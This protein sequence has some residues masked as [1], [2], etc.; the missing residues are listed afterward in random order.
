MPSQRI[1]ERLIEGV[2]YKVFKDGNGVEFKIV[3]LENTK[4]CKREGIIE[5][6]ALKKSNRHVN[7]KVVKRFM[8]R[9]QELG[10][11]I[12]GVPMS[13]D[14]QTKEIKWRAFTIEDKLTLDLSIPEQAIAWAVIKNSPFIEGSPNQFGKPAYKV[15]D[16]EAKAHK[17][18]S[19]RMVKRECEDIIM[20]LKG[21]ALI[22][23]AYHVGVNVKANPNIFMLT[24]QIFSIMEADPEKF[25][26]SYKDPNR[27]YATVFKKALGMGI[28]T[29][30][31]KV[32]EY[33]YNS[34]PLGT[35]EE[36]AIKYLAENTGISAA[37]NSRCVQLAK[38]SFDS[39]TVKKPEAQESDKV[40]ELEAEL[41]RLRDERESS[42]K[43]VVA[44]VPV[45]DLGEAPKVNNEE[46]LKSLRE[47][48]KE[49]KIPGYNLPTMD[50]AKLS[51][52]IQEAEEKSQS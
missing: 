21:D 12:W 9:T 44:E 19:R 27:Q 41:K 52:K 34:L 40:A 2:D 18:V 31:I 4:Y 49:L 20:S 33:Y 37:I 30:D 36:L 8:D 26:A 3:N 10:G 23:L 39:M 28:I 14:D 15:I 7:H 24:E 25:L 46:I 11:L 17:E 13:I 5:I 48:A 50:I 38:D 6:E 1:N 43:E 51:K 42:K 29:H 47:R 32:G 35:R 16:K 45:F 22:E